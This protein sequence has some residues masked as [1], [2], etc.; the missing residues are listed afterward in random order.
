MGPGV[1]GSS[2]WWSISTLSREKARDAAPTNAATVLGS[3]GSSSMA[4]GRTSNSATAT[5]TPP[6]SAIT[7]GSDDDHLERLLLVQ[8]VRLEVELVLADLELEPS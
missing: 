5:T 4:S 1:D 8:P 7:V 6:L 3:S 2:R